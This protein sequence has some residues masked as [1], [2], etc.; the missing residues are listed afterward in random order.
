MNAPNMI[1]AVET[2]AEIKWFF[3]DAPSSWEPVEYIRKDALLEW[4]RQTREELE[5]QNAIKEDIRKGAIFQ[6]EE[7]VEKLN[8][9]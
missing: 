2:E 3:G 1:S 4:A 9:M 7:L 6:L 8:T 5:K